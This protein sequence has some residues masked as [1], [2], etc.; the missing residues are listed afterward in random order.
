MPTT[1]YSLILPFPPS[2]NRAY[3]AVAGRVV[4]SKAARQYGVA[5]RNA[6]PVGR[7]ERIAGRLRVV[8]TVHPPAR[9]VGRAWDVANREKLLSDALTKAGFWRDDSQI[10]SFRV[11]RG[12]FLETRPAGC[13][14][15]DVEVL[16]P[17]RFFP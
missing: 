11:D 9:L 2:L 4:L 10:D 14:V 15:V 17:V 16:A 13:A 5:V 8:V 3:R 7:A 12:E 6:L 1:R